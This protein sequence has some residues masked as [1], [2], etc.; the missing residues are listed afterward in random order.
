MV[1][2][3]PAFK[4]STVLGLAALV[5]FQVMC[6]TFFILE[7]ATDVLGLRHWAVTWEVRE[8]LQ[9]GASIGLI[10]GS[11]ASILLLRRTLRHM[12]RV[13]QQLRAASGMFLDAMEDQ[14][15][16]WDLSPT[17]KDVALFAIRGYSN[18]EIAAARGRSEATIKTQLNA[19]FR[20]AGFSGRTN[21]VSHFIDLLVEAAPPGRLPGAAAATAVPELADDLAAAPASAAPDTVTRPCL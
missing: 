14:F 13:E 21:L 16:A 7:L 20:K 3:K 11:V 6:A 10:L 12:G 2:I 4:R 1:P 8:A 9:I 18:A 15:D 5:V 17:E 19:V